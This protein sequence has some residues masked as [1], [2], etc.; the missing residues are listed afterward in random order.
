VRYSPT[1]TP[2]HFKLR[3]RDGQL[4]FQVN[5]QGIGIPSEDLPHLFE[6]FDH[7]RNVSNIPGTGLGLR[8][9][10]KFVDLQQGAIAVQSKVGQGTTFT[11]HL[12]H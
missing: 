12:P 5:N 10:K 8:I 4:I 6:P 1:A 2:I 7:G 9:V 3:R 11:V